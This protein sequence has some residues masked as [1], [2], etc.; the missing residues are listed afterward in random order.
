MTIEQ[1]AITLQALVNHI[2]QQDWNVSVTD[3][4]TRIYL[5]DDTDE[6]DSLPGEAE[7]DESDEVVC[8]TKRIANQVEV[9]NIVRKK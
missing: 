8:Y 5:H 2:R 7:I 4:A 1:V 3:R 9:T 6:F